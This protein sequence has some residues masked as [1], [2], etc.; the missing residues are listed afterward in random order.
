MEK[1]R[2]VRNETIIRCV[3]YGT[4]SIPYGEYKQD[5]Q[6]IPLNCGTSVR[7]D[8]VRYGT[9][10]ITVLVRYGTGYPT[11]QVPTR[12][13]RTSKYL[14]GANQVPTKSRTS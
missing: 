10:N 11:K 8:T 9:S 7:Y 12:Y 2:K 13:L 4:V 14:S 3:K 1:G 6:K 5:P